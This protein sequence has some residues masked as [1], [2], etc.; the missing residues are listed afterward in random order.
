ML[1]KSK[2]YSIMLKPAK[3]ALLNFVRSSGGLGVLARSGWRHNRILILGYHGVSLADEHVWD[4]S[5][6]VTPDFLRRRFQLIKDNH[7]N[8]LPLH[9]AVVRLSQ[10]TLPEKTVVITFDDG[11]YNF[12]G[13][14]F[15]IIKDSD[16]PVTLYLT[17]FYSGYNRPVFATAASYLLWSAGSRK[18]SLD[19]VLGIDEGTT[20][21][22]SIAADRKKAHARL[23]A[24]ALKSNLSAETKDGILAKLCDELEIDF[25][26][27]CKR[28]AFQLLN[29]SE[30]RYLSQQGL[31]IQLHTHRHRVPV[32]QDLFSEEIE[33][34][35]SFIQELTG[36]PTQHFCYPSGVFD[37]QFPSWL[38]SLDVITAVTSAPGLV[39]QNTSPYRLPR[40][41]DSALLS[42]VEFEGW[43]SGFSQLLPSRSSL[44]LNDQL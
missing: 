28:R 12:Y 42:E 34:N 36:G 3:K 26:A 14:A 29:A 13:S 25:D 6:F 16:F 10:G 35:R 37:K 30:I 27:F 11:F 40:I 32:D 23:V 38:R 19:P 33:K 7:C 15:P 18:L 24:F 4:P 21:D 20:F 44:G 2:Q 22:L 8:V 31:D 17:T 5:L 43:L 1:V 9:E 41:I 39:N